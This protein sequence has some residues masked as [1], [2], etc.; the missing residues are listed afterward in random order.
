[1]FL[2]AVEHHVWAIGA[3]QAIAEEEGDNSAAKIGAVRTVATTSEGP[4][5]APDQRGFDAAS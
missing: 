4:R 2:D 5:E 1:L 3:A